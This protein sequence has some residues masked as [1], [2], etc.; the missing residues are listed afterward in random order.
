MKTLLSNE[1][2][3]ILRRINL[4]NEQ[5]VAYKFGDLFIAENSITGQKRQLENVPSNIAENSNKSSLL[6]G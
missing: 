3:A 1:S 4:I 2:Q 6:K 5:E